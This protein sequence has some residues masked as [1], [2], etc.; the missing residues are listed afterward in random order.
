MKLGLV[1]PAYNEAG[2]IAEVL[3]EI[4]AGLAS[5]II[6]VDNGSTDETAALA[7]ACGA[8]V[9][10]EERRGYGQA[11]FVGTTHLHDDIEAIGFLDADGSDDPRQ[12]PQLLLPIERGE[13]DLVVS[14]RTLGDAQEKLTVQQ[15][16][17]NRLAVGLIHLLWGHR[18]TDLG[19]MRVVRRDALER[20]DLRERTWGWP[21]SCGRCKWP[22]A[23]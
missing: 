19:P 9:V 10:R 4:P 3:R 23:V 1:I 11:R 12:L 8:E 21:A 15:R 14:A 16:F 7:R 22:S 18:Y 6:V 2:C 13:A 20:L 5:Q 17:G